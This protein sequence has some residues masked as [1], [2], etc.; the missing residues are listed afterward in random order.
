MP[1]YLG[2][3]LINRHNPSTLICWYY[4][5]SVI[6]SNNIDQTKPGFAFLSFMQTCRILEK[7]LNV[8]SIPISRNLA[9]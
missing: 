6:L 2:S 9:P 1:F 5:E 8:L 3:I 7:S 4:A